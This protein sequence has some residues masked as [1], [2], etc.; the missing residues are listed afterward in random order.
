M[1]KLQQ[2][3]GPPVGMGAVLIQD[4]AILEKWVAPNDIVM[5]YS[6]AVSTA[7]RIESKCKEYGL[8]I[9]NRTKYI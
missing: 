2:K 5:M 6:D 3:D 1:K 4:L 9:V 7:A 8:C